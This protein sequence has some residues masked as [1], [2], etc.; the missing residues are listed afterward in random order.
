MDDL[1][2][3]LG[4]VRHFRDLPQTALRAIVDA[5]QIR[6]FSAGSVIFIEG[7]PCAGMFVLLSGRVHLCKTGQR[8]QQQIIGII[9][10]VI[11]FNEVAMLDGGSNPLMAL[12]MEDCVTWNLSC[13]AFRALVQTYPVVGLGLLPVLA[14]RNRVLLSRYE[15]LSNRSVLAR[16]A[17]L[18]LDMSGD[19][20][21]AIDRREHSIEEMAARIGSVREPVSRA[22]R[23]LREDGII[24]CTRTTII[25]SQ[26]K[27]L[28]RQAHVEV[29]AT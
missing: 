29:L 25:V 4:R 10:P 8:G 27:E 15:D 12:A 19:G 18:L 14:A 26:P 7:E 28:A 16:T 6:R 5:G 17:K 23:T 13:E 11:M 24:A 22:L 20:R 3:R 2:A 21:R 1:T 9:E